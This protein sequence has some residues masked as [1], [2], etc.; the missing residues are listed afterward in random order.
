VEHPSYV[1]LLEMS[2]GHE[3]VNQMQYGV[4]VDD[5]VKADGAGAYGSTTSLNTPDRFVV[6]IDVTPVI[7]IRGTVNN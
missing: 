3:S 4:V 7:V 5:P 1:G 2:G 6:L